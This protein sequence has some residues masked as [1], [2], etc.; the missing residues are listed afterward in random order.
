M[1]RETCLFAG[2]LLGLAPFLAGARSKGAACPGDLPGRH[3]VST[4]D[5]VDSDAETAARPPASSAT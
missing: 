1:H 5:W 2:L 4:I 3:R